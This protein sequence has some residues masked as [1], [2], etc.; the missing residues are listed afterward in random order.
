MNCKFLND[1]IKITDYLA[2]KNKYPISVKR[3]IYWYLSPFRF[4][5]T[6]SFKVDN[7]KN[8][9][10]DFGEGFGGTLID[11]IIKLE[12]I[13]VKEIIS[14]Y[15]NNNFSFQKLEINNSEDL[16]Q[17][18]R[19]QILERKPVYSYVLKSYLRDRGIYSNKAYQY[20]E[21]IKF[22]I[23]KCSE[24]FALGFQNID[25][26]YELR[27]KIFKGCSGKNLS[28][29]LNNENENRVFIFEGFF[30]FLSF[31][32]LN[33]YPNFNF[34]VMNSITNSDRL[35][36]HLNNV[37]YCEIH[38]YLDNDEAGDNCTNKL[39]NQ[40]TNSVIDHRMEFKNQNDLNEFHISKLNKK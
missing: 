23:E 40:F 7:S 11:L 28:M 26:N 19:I 5:K 36:T 9:F 31:M 13:T 14:K 30:D 21:E 25:G 16:I 20:V 33:N 10:Y 15:S 18:K 27:N 6:S 32:E 24:Q 34:I 38:L 12:N 3:N 4:E 35:I 8:L 37:N 39:I 1:N 22:K 2:Q 17:S 29:I